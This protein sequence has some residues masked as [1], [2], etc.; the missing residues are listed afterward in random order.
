[1]RDTLNFSDLPVDVIS[2]LGD[3]MNQYELRGRG[4]DNQR[5][6]QL[7]TP[8]RTLD[9]YSDAGRAI[10]DNDLVLLGD[11]LNVVHINELDIVMNKILP[12]S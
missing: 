8:S 10:R 6:N 1:M 4:Y 12:I 3:Y 2:S 9:V 5:W 7:I 11:I